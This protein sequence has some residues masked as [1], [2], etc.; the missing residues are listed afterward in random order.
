LHQKG[1]G[2]KK[3]EREQEGSDKKED[4]K[5]DSGGPERWK[6]EVKVRVREGGS[7]TGGRDPQ[8]K[9]KAAEGLLLPR[10]RS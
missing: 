1:V 2:G 10:V 7:P 6:E 8:K 3:S 5:K 4:G 9:K